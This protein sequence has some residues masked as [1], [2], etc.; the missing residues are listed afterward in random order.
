MSQGTLLDQ[1]DDHKTTQET[2]DDHINGEGD[3][4]TTHDHHDDQHPDEQARRDGQGQQ[5]LS[6]AGP[7][8]C[9]SILIHAML[10]VPSTLER[11][12]PMTTKTHYSLKTLMST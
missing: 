10:D 12:P 1:D 7:P 3:N 11:K 5:P 8:L 2:L 4:G 9:M 6:H